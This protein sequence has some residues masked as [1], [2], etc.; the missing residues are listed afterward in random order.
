MEGRIG[1]ITPGAFADIVAVDGNPL[2]NLDL[3]TGQGSHMP[4]IMKGGVAVKEVG[5]F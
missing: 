1:A 2:E 4:L 5:S 3:L